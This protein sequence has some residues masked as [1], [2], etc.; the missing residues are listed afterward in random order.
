MYRNHICRRHALLFT[1]QYAPRSARS[2]FTS[3]VLTNFTV[4]YPTAVQVLFTTDIV[5]AGL[6]IC[7]IGG[8]LGLG[9]IA[10]AA[11]TTTGGHLKAKF[12]FSTVVATAFT[13]SLAATTTSKAKSTALIVIAAAGIGMLESLTIVAVT[14]VIKDQSELGAGVGAYGSIRSMAGVIASKFLVASIKKVNANSDIS[15][16]LCFRPD[17]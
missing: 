17:Q 14:I 9:E 12:I 1:E 8:G 6:L 4:V 15:C 3:S 10:G 5:Y 11:L 16:Y 13:A 7:A 2:K